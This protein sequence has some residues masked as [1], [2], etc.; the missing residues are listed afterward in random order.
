MGLTRTRDGRNGRGGQRS[1]L[2]LSKEEAE[3]H[4]LS[5]P[6]TQRAEIRDQGK[7][8]EGEMWTCKVCLAECHHVSLNA[9]SPQAS[10]SMP[11]TPSPETNMSHRP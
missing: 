6:T 8:S 4:M 3:M 5:Q 7:Y 2:Y 1:V 9:S 11:K 10:F